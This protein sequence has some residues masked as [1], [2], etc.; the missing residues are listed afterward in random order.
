MPVAL[1]VDYAQLRADFCKGVPLKD[2]A[3]THN[4]NVGSLRS[5]AQRE[6]W[7][8]IKQKAEHSLMHHAQTEIVEASRK[9][10]KSI[11]GYTDAAL[12]NIVS[13]GFDDKPATLLTLVTIADKLDQITRRTLRMDEQSAQSV[14]HLAVQVNVNNSGSVSG[15]NS[16]DV[17]DVSDS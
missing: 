6:E 4:L 12:A 15:T 9:H 16:C 13:R 2:L 17:I 10:V 8:T 14:P 3:D 11:L 7:S 5:R 1:P